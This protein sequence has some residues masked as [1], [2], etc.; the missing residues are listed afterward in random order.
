VPRVDPEK[1]RGTFAA[2]HKAI[3][4][5]LVRACHD[6]SEGGLAAALAEMAFAGGLGAHIAANLAPR[7]QD[8]DDPAVILFSES[9]TRFICEVEPASAE[10]FEACF[11]DWVACKQIGSVQ[12]N[13]TLE[14]RFNE[15]IVIAADIG[16]LKRAWKT[17]LH[18]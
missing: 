9:N 1:S 12:S 5:G 13:S 10:Q 8:G 3:A 7:A 17:L 18:A 11:R 16:E 15:R 2:L 6:L 4:S 14:I